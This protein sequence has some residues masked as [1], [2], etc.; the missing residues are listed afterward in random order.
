MLGAIGSRKRAD[1]EVCD[2]ECACSTSFNAF[3][4]LTCCCSVHKMPFSI[5]SVFRRSPE[6]LVKVGDVNEVMDKTIG[7]LVYRISGTV[8]AKNY[9]AFPSLSIHGPNLY[10]QMAIQSCGVATMHLEI[11]TTSGH[12]IRITL[13]TLYEKDPPRFF[14][15]SLRLPLPLITGWITFLLDLR[16]IVARYCR[17]TPDTSA[18]AMEF[19]CLKK[20]QVCSNVLVRDIVSAE[21]HCSSTDPLPKDLAVKPHAPLLPP[22]DLVQYCAAICVGDNFQLPSSPLIYSPP[23]RRAYQTDA[24]SKVAANR[25]PEHHGTADTTATTTTAARTQTNDS[26]LSSAMIEASPFPLNAREIALAVQD[27]HSNGLEMRPTEAMVQSPVPT[28]MPIPTSAET[29]METPF[30]SQ[31]SSSAPFANAGGRL[32]ALDQVLG[33]RG[34]CLALLYNGRMLLTAVG[35]NLLMVDLHFPASA[36]VEGLWKAFNAGR[37]RNMA[38]SSQCLLKGHNKEVTLLEV[39]PNERYLASA[40]SSALCGS[41]IL[42]DL[43]DGRRLVTVKPCSGYL[44]CVAFNVSNSQMVTVGLDQLSRHQIIVWDIALLISTKGVVDAGSGSLHPS[45]LAKQLSEYPIAH[46]VFSRCEGTGFISCGRENIRLWRVRKGHL[47]GRPIVLNNY[48]RGHEYSTVAYEVAAQVT[49]FFYVASSKGL[50]LKVNQTTEQV[51][52]AFQLHADAIVSFHIHNNFAVTGGADNRL[53]VW[54]LDF[55]DYLLEARHEGCVSNIAVGAQGSML[56]VGTVAGTLGVLSVS[57]HS[58]RTALRSHTAGIRQIIMNSNCSELASVSADKTIRVWNLSTG[59]QTLEFLSD[60]DV[61]TCVCWQ[62]SEPYLICGFS[63]GLVR[64]FDLVA[65]KS[66]L[67]VKLHAS[68]VVQLIVFCPSEDKECLL[69]VDASGCFLVCDIAA[70]FSA[71]FKIQLDGDNSTPRAMVTKAAD[72]IAIGNGSIDSVMV[73]DTSDWSSQ[74]ANACGNLTEAPTTARTDLKA[75]RTTQ[76]GKGSALVG[77]CFLESE[78]KSLLIVSE[79]HFVVVPHSCI[80][81][82]RLIPRSQLF[83][84]TGACA[85]DSIISKRHDLERICGVFF[86]SYSNML[87]VTF[88]HD[89][90]TFEAMG[91]SKRVG[92]DKARDVKQSFAVL[93]VGLEFSDISSPRLLVSTP[94]FYANC[95]GSTVLS[96]ASKLDAFDKIITAD[97]MG[98]ISY[99]HVCRAV[100]RDMTE[101]AVWARSKGP[102]EERC[103]IDTND[104]KVT[105]ESFLDAGLQDI[106]TEFLPENRQLVDDLPSPHSVNSVHSEDSLLVDQRENA[107]F[108]DHVDVDTTRRQAQAEVTPSKFFDFEDGSAASSLDKRDSGFSRKEIGEIENATPAATTTTTTTTNYSQFLPP[109]FLDDED[110]LSAAVGSLSNGSKLEKIEDEF[111]LSMESMALSEIIA[112][113][114][115]QLPLFPASTS[116]LLSRKHKQWQLYFGLGSSRCPDASF[117]HGPLSCRVQCIGECSCWFCFIADGCSRAA[118]MSSSDDYC[119]ITDGSTVRSHSC[120][121]VVTDLASLDIFSAPFNP[122]HPLLVDHVQW[123]SDFRWSSCGCCWDFGGRK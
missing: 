31:F 60:G 89:L 110:T 29:Q 64:V 26:H 99:W 76:F 1:G 22:L 43:E 118:D 23:A 85:V 7:R 117:G 35:A 59:H 95:S 77:L 32:L 122:Q 92:A 69:S 121:P 93:F 6:L 27:L 56:A 78:D 88:S 84:S 63:S 34:G 119:A 79:T 106:S 71:I 52:C 73:V 45:I 53:R 5:F 48:S 123:K 81:R 68:E 49:V 98:C 55:S 94:Q 28:D 24:H 37:V 113:S 66:V 75:T 41:V 25:W 3:F 90:P 4:G 96:I 21:Q 36:P 30:P 97:E 9:A 10:M 103:I 83:H 16:A 17:S 107:F 50:V 54:P 38:G 120:S 2:G 58:Y 105:R 116:E 87:L 15:R 102:A 57:E 61:P 8:S 112:G 13:S 39:S 19:S 72:L 46:I 109:K 12:S 108:R 104:V 42:W 111:L 114:R 44:Q 65:A 18:A 14:G 80:S 86:D 100:L 20:I 70:N 33:Y 62:T 101:H 74:T 47:P 51:M 40:E 115:Q 82:K 11:L 67:E 91:K